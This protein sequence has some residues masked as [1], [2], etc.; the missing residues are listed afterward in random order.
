MTPRESAAIP[1]MARGHSAVDGLRLLRQR[2]PILVVTA[3]LGTAAAIAYYTMT[4][5]WYRSEIMI[6]PKESGLGGLGTVGAMLGDLPFDVGAAGGGGNSDAERISA[7]LQSRS[8]TD[9]VIKKFDLLERYHLDKI[10]KARLQVW[11][12]CNTKVDKKPNLVVLTC[13]DTEPEVARD[14]A[15]Y[16]GQVGDEGFRRIASSSASEERK[17]LE[18]RVTEAHADLDKASMALRVFQEKNKI[19]DLPEQSKAVVSAMAKLEGDVISKRVQL[20]YLSGFASNDESSASQLGRQIQVLRREIRTLEQTRS[21]ALEVAGAAGAARDKRG[22]DEPDMFPPA[23]Q[24]PELRYQ[25]E[26]L[27]REQKIRETVFFLLTER[28]ESLKIDEARDLSTF[29]VFDHAA[30]PTHRVRPRMRV[31]PIGMM[32][33]LLFGIMLITV[34]A[35]WRDLRRRAAVER[36]S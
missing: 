5:R 15:E 23:M 12:L 13:E 31:V 36:A 34:P 8:T 28:Y 17:F 33:G 11:S 30:L 1:A 4:P 16:F 35:W 25:L 22:A 20:A 24:V 14:M 18:K 27:F 21:P 32:G 3:V 29:V 19:I 7:I 2:W 6:V 10:E 9:A 26:A